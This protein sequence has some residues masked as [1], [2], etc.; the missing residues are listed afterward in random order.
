MLILL[1]GAA[2]LEV[3][4]DALIR[5]GIK[6]G[7]LLLVLLGAVVLV[8]YGFL[9]NLTSLDFSRLMGLYIVV[10]L[11]SRKWLLLWSF[12]SAFPCLCASVE[13]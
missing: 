10:F 3:G 7:G 8:S 4:G 9:V 1:I 5:A 6:G 12:A 2:V 11:R 13:R